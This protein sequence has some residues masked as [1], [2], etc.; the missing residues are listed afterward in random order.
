MPAA[1]I[2]A[3]IVNCALPPLNVPEPRLVPPLES[4]TVPVGVPPS[5]LTATVTVVLSNVVMLDG[6]AETVTAGVNV[7]PRPPPVLTELVVPPHAVKQRHTG[8]L[9]QNAACRPALRIVAETFFFIAFIGIG[10]CF[11]CLR[12]IDFP[13]FGWNRRQPSYHAAASS[14]PKAPALLLLH[15]AFP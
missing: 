2:P 9:N 5:P 7:V 13:C 3:A 15:L 6:L 10:L 11:L 12:R 8:M 14:S 1:S 4:V